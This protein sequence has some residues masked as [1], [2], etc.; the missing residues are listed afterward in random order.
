MK[1]Q[2]GFMLVDTSMSLTRRIA[3]VGSIPS[4]YVSGRI[5]GGFGP[6]ELY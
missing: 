4:A 3:N 1:C 5:L 2:S 6:T